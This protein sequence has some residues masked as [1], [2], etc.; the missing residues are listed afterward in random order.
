MCVRTVRA[1]HLL[2]ILVVALLALCPA[3]ASAATRY[4]KPAATGAGDCSSWSDACTLQTALTGAAAGD[5]IWVMAGIHSPGS[6][7][8]DTFQLKDG[9]AVYGGFGGTESALSQRNPQA[10]VTFL[11]GE[12]V[13]YHVVT[14]S[15]TDTTAVLDGFTVRRGKADGLVPDDCGAGMYNDAGSPS[16]TNVIFSGNSANGS[17]GGM[18]NFN[19]SSPALSNVTFYGNSAYS[20][21]G[22][23]NESGSPTL[24]DVTFSD[25][26]ASWG[27]GM[28]NRDGSSPALI[29]VAFSGNSASQYGGGMYNDSSS[30]TLS[31]VVF[32][33]NSAT[34][35]GSSHGGGMYNKAANPTL[36]SVTF[37]GNS[38]NSEGGGMSNWNGSSPTLSN[39]TFSGNSAE[40]SGGGMENKGSSPTLSNVTFS[41]NLAYSV[42]GGMY[43]D[44]AGAHPTLTNVILWAD[45]AGINGSEISNNFSNPTITDSV[46]KGGCPA[47]STCSNVITSDPMLGPLADNGGFTRTHALLPGSSA[48][49]AGG[50]NSTCEDTDQRGVTRPQGTACDIGAYEVLAVDMG[51]SKGASS[52]VV[53]AGS[54]A[55]NLVYTVTVTNNGP[56][57]ATGFAVSESLTLPVGVT[58]DSLTPSAG[59]VSGASPSYTWTIGSLANGESATLTVALT[60]GAGTPPGTDMI[61]D[62]ASVAAVDQPESN[63]ANDS[64]TEATSVIAPTS[65]TATKAVS[66]SF[67][68]GGTVTYTVVLANAGPADAMDDQSTDELTDVLPAEL[69]LVSASATSGTA[70]ADA[71]TNTMTW[72]GAIPVGSPVTIT[73][74]ATVGDLGEG[75]LVS[76]QG[77]ARYDADGDGTHEATALTDDPGTA[78]PEDATVF[79]VA[80]KPG[81][82][83]ASPAGLAVLIA[84]LALAG[85]AVIRRRL[86]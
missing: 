54:G 17:G 47:G 73:I 53:T 18:A 15:G 82:P 59:S 23:C 75:V 26:S 43:N 77:E 78:S 80:K 58:V 11:S 49:D 22:L 74:T 48:V 55:G 9:V 6:N 1:G 42:G 28:N 5:E 37:S 2:T 32:S 68:P 25:N 33:G 10:N 3:A 57:D 83:T 85:A 71:G 35:Y 34:L 56:N 86:V 65:V 72:N 19:A 46:V 20:G 45:L 21:G 52:D 63:A 84:L 38:S 31:D 61:S 39:V 4:A 44:G 66:G 24:T 62:T 76:N 8:S 60:V 81:I 50:V 14:G 41:A 29:R 51:V 13:N 16:L 27:G 67:A 12:H 64:A 30:P 40:F 70:V 79:E 7:R 69:T 36:D